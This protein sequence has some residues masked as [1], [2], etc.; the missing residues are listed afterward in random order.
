[1]ATQTNPAPV[2]KNTYFLSGALKAESHLATCGP[3]LA[4][5]AGKKNPTPIPTYNN[6]NGTFMYMP[7]AGL[8]SKLRGAAC[9]L[10]L[11]ALEAKQAR[12][13]TLQDAQLNRVGGIKQGGSENALNMTAYLE[14]IRANPLLGV[15][16]AA[17][18]WIKGKAMVGHV[19]C[20]SPN[21]PPMHV[22]G[23]RSDIL[24]REPAIVEYLAEGALERYSEDTERTKAYQ[25]VKAKKEE[26][27]L[28]AKRGTPEERKVARLEITKLEKQIKD[29][30]LQQVS[31]QMPLTGYLA[32]PPGAELENKM[33]LLGVSN[34]E[35]GCFVAALERFAEAPV[36]GAHVGH[37]AGV[38]SGSWEI[39]KTREGRI[40]QLTIV[41][42]TGLSI[43]GQELV[44]AKEAFYSF[45]AS[46]EFQPYVNMAS[47][48]ASTKEGAGDE[49]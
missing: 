10:L 49:E 30:D 22:E 12:R 37:G 11:E 2:S 39:N 28:A 16:G 43:D 42:F 24:K 48:M 6:G 40:G 17:T 35:L 4:A 5:R 15:F 36:L 45:I 8:R 29:E 32:I 26:L 9:E 3:S 44:D 34:I 47:M 7:G 27:E 46:D 31:A 13:F 20:K 19:N 23:V 21:V 25:L 1:M 18:P 41:P 38:I 14:M 33:S